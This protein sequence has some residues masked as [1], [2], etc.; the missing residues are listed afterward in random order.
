MPVILTSVVSFLLLTPQMGTETGDVIQVAKIGSQALFLAMVVAMLTTRIYKFIDSKNL[1]IKMP[2]AVPPAVS[3]PFESIIPSFIIVLMFWALRL[4][5]EGFSDMSALELINSTLGMPIKALGGSIF[6]VIAAKIIE[7]LLWFFG[8]HGGSIVSGVMTPVFQV[9]EDANKAA[10]IAGTPLPNIISNSFYTHFAGIGIVGSVVAIII[11]SKSKRYREMGKIAGVPYLFNIGEP[12]LFGIPLML[13]VTFLI[14]FVFTCA[15]SA[16]VA[17]IA[18]AI[19]IVP[20][21]TGLVQLPWDNSTYNQWISGNWKHYGWSITIGIDCD[22][23]YHLDS[24][25][26][27]RGQKTCS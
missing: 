22:F 2:A 13:N 26:Q 19:G 17:Y 14:P 20:I 3:A 18:F 25:H 27:N 1:K 24:I 15:I 6:G 11:V 5:L 23:N 16:I 10:S 4:V 21:P 9:L 7:Q 8:I 12:A